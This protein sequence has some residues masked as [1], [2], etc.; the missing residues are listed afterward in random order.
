MIGFMAFDRKE[1]WIAKAG[2]TLKVH[3]MLSTFSPLQW[4]L[5]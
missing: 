1:G 5:D 4:A 3:K 2:Q